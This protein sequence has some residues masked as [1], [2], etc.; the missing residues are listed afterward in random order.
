MNMIVDIQLLLS[1]LR[2]VL[3]NMMYLTDQNVAT[4]SFIRAMFFSSNENMWN[5]QTS[6]Y[7]KRQMIQYKKGVTENEILKYYYQNIYVQQ[8]TENN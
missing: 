5:V 3:K 4:E 1:Q 2:E 6:L 8:M 7:V